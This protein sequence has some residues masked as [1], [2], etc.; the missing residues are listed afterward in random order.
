MQTQTVH[1]AASASN[2]KAV[3]VSQA[4]G[5]HAGAWRPP[6]PPALPHRRR[7][8]PSGS[9]GNASASRTAEYPSKVAATAVAKPNSPGRDQNRL[10]TVTPTSAIPN[11]I[12]HCNA[13]ARER[14]PAQRPTPSSA[15][16]PGKLAKPCHAGGR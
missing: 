1:S 15:A 10:Q 3:R 9:A 8:R 12:R 14:E 2:P 4:N 16:K 5:I 11:T 6:S 7:R 13:M